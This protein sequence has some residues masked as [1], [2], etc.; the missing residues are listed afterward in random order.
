MVLKTS[1]QR[2]IVLPFENTA[3]KYIM[4]MIIRGSYRRKKM[5]MDNYAY[6][7]T[8]FTKILMYPDQC[9]YIVKYISQTIYKY[10]YLCVSI[11]A[12]NHN[13]KRSSIFRIFGFSDILLIIWYLFIILSYCVIT[14]R[15]I[16]SLPNI[17]CVYLCV[18]QM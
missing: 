8:F 14:F 6:L 2:L 7:N 12:I 17:D 10:L 13:H 5:Y 18:P 16:C 4:F 1:V 3:M 15:G 11:V 9:D